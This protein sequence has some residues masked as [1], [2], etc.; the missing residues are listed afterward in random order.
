VPEGHNPQGKILGVRPEQD[1]AQGF[2]PGLCTHPERAVETR[3][4]PLDGAKEHRLEAY[5]TLFSGPAMLSRAIDYG[6]GASD[7][8]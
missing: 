8:A 2:K 7:F 5:A 6:H 3:K 1:S 4:T